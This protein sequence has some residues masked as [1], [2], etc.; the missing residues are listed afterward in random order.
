MRSPCLLTAR[1]TKL[2]AAPFY[3]MEGAVFWACPGCSHATCLK[4][5]LTG[6]GSLALSASAR[7]D[8]GSRAPAHDSSRSAPAAGASRWTDGGLR[9]PPA[10]DRSHSNRSELV[11]AMLERGNREWFGH[12]LRVACTRRGMPARQCVRRS[13]GAE[14]EAGDDGTRVWRLGF[15]TV[16]RLCRALSRR[17]PAAVPRVLKSGG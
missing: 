5:G 4:Y 8:R 6:P 15:K 11:F 14:D 2:I 3:E 7:V 1:R 16:R 12:G 9:L 13:C 10:T 17:A